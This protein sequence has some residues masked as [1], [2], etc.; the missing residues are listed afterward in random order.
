MEKRERKHPAVFKPRTH[1]TYY[2]DPQLERVARVSIE[3]TWTALRGTCRALLKTFAWPGCGLTGLCWETIEEISKM[4]SETVLLLVFLS[5]LSLLCSAWRYMRLLLLGGFEAHS[6]HCQH[7]NG[8]IT[9]QL[10]SN[11][12]DI[13]SMLPN[14]V[15]TPAGFEVVLVL[16]YLTTPTASVVNASV[17]I[18]MRDFIILTTHETCR[19]TLVC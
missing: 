1:V 19:C 7:T 11:F 13:F 9:V 8:R 2:A 4:K 5:L 6:P 12:L 18:P 10:I 15:E 3:A 16:F 14:E 17:S